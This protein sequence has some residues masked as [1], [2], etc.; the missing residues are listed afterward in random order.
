MLL[1]L[2]L[3]FVDMDIIKVGVMINKL[4]FYEYIKVG[5]ITR[6]YV[7]NICIYTKVD[8]IFSFGTGDI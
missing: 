2:D 7:F 3:L 6:L 8:N 4:C 1:S 5:A